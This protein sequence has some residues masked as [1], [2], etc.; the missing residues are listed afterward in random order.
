[1]FSIGYNPRSV[2]N[3]LRSFLE[4]VKLNFINCISI[5]MIVV[6]GTVEVEDNWHII[7]GEIPVI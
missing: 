3:K 6:V 5:A 2:K 7:F 1:M 4:K